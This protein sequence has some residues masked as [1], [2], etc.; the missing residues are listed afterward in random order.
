MGTMNDEV[1]CERWGKPGKWT[2][3]DWQNH[4]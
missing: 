2:G 1:M 3:S 4:G